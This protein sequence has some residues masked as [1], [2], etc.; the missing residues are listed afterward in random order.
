MY[1]C[2]FLDL[3]VETTQTHTYTRAPHP[4]DIQLLP[5]SP[6]KIKGDDEMKRKK[7]F[8]F[9]FLHCI[10]LVNFLLC[11]TPSLICVMS[12]FFLC[13]QP[14]HFNLRF[15]LKETDSDKQNLFFFIYSSVACND[16]NM[17][18]QGKRMVFHKQ[19]AYKYR[20][21]Q[22]CKKAPWSRYSA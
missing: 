11:P 14:R 13:N 20:R 5:C 10:I 17:N 4:F 2:L 8:V 6:M 3:I 12:P 18:E 1:G 15:L 21:K 19:Y 9:D 16:T 7:T 22:G